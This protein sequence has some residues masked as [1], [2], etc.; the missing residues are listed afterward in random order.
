MDEVGNARDAHRRGGLRGG[1]LHPG[2]GGHLLHPLSRRQRHCLHAPR[3]I[4]AFQSPQQ[5]VEAQLRTGI[6]QL[7]VL[8]SQREE[9]RSRVQALIS[10]GVAPALSGFLVGDDPG[11]A[12]YVRLKE[13]AAGRPGSFEIAALDST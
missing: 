9:L 12:S 10:R 4:A 11:S 5:R 7:D 13:K 6:A 8:E 1:L 2:P 3:E